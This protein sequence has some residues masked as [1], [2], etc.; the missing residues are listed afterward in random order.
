MIAEIIASLKTTNKCPHC[1]SR[2]QK[3]K[4]EKPTTFLEN[5]KGYRLLK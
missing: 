5:E 1:R 4:L 3:I 2:Q